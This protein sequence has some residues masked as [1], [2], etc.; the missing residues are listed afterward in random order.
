MRKPVAC[1][2]VGKSA[3]RQVPLETIPYAPDE[4]E[5]LNGF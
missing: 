1:S 4:V 5:K 2:Q 3:E